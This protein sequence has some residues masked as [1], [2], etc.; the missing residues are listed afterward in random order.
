MIVKFHF[1]S[2]SFEWKTFLKFYSLTVK[3]NYRCCVHLSTQ[4]WFNSY[5]IVLVIKELFFFQRMYA[6]I[7]A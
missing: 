5:K 3:I 4:P 6:E 1:Q 2:K 7:V